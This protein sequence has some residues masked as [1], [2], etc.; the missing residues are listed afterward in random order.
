MPIDQGSTERQG[1][2][3]ES[4]L[5]ILKRKLILWFVW[6][7]LGIYSRI[8]GRVGVGMLEI[9]A[10]ATSLV[11]SFLVPLVRKG[12]DGLGG[13]LREMTTAVA[14]DGLV[15][16]AQRLWARVKGTPRS[17]NDQEIVAMFERQPDVMQ[18]ALVKVVQRQLEEDEGFRTDVATLLEAEAAPG[19]PSWK[20]MGE[21]VGAV[22]AR[23]AT[24]S[25]GTVAGV[26]Y[27]ASPPDGTHTSEPADGKTNRE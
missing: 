19:V 24:I 3:E 13:G 17:P 26:V 7:S 10:M 14:A 1:S 8:A 15:K 11:V 23:N 25:G 4:C 2:I 12:P 27:H 22:D 9:A 6:S 21:I 20:L 5:R 18:E 16:T